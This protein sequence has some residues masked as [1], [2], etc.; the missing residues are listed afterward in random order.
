MNYIYTQIHISCVLKIDR[1]HHVSLISP[2]N[3]NIKLLL[4]FDYQDFDILRSY[5]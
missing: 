2:I 4:S 5:I 1:F 3:V